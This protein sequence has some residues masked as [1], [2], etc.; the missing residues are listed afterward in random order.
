MITDELLYRITIFFMALCCIV[1][2]YN[3]LIALHVAISKIDM[4]EIIEH[5][6]FLEFTR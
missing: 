6:L 3:R 2:R 1:C 4:N 5:M